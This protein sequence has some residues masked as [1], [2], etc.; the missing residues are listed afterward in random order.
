MSWM[1]LRA[2]ISLCLLFSLCYVT[3]W[4][5]KP[6]G[7]AQVNPL[8]PK[9]D[10]VMKIKS[11]FTLAAVGDILLHHSISRFDDPR[12][13]NLISQLRSADVAFGNLETPI[14]DYSD[15]PNDGMQEGMPKACLPDLK[16]MGIRIM[17]CANNHTMQDGVAGMLATIRGL[18]QAG[19][20]HAGSGQNLQE[21]RMPGFL[22]TPKGTVGLVGVFSIDPS[23][24]PALASSSGATYQTGDQ[25]GVPGVD[26]LHLTQYNI[27]TPEQLQALRK[28]RDS[29]Y[30]LRN[31]V[32]YPVPALAANEPSDRLQLFGQWYKTGPKPG[33][34]SWAM[35]QED[36][37][38]ILRSIKDGKESA[39]FMI[40]TIHCHQN[41]WAIQKYTFDSDIPDFLVEFAHEAIDNG[42]DVFIGHGVH[43][44]RG[45]EIYKG[46]PIFY[47]LGSFINQPAGSLLPQNPGGT[48]TFA[49]ASN[50]PTG[51]PGHEGG[52]LQEPVNREALMT[53]S[54]YEGGRLVEVKLYPVDNGQSPSRP[55]SR[56]GIPMTP[57]PEVA[58]EI[59]ER[60]Q[61][62]SARFGTSIVIEGNVGVIRVPAK[63]EGAR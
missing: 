32:L 18:D 45:V 41:T 49:E 23:T 3:S 15:V 7:S 5:G 24:T 40:V 13:Q 27:V 11:S 63:D 20:A 52:R 53:T 14:V 51:A 1:R 42:A 54:R 39:D 35:N 9:R 46:K 22:D 56:V 8:P 48:L 4:A 12:F 31:E 28:I 30:A 25:P 37:K 62:A 36:L 16:A 43:T 2:T 21:A 55:L 57:S 6:L 50:L 47:G 26:G 29:I 34:L 60:V 33:E 17:N 10:L 44:L 59:L 61:K 58:R 19:I 38:E